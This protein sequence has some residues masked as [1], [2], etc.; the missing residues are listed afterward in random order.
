MPLAA[1]RAA[2]QQLLSM[3]RKDSQVAAALDVSNAR[4]KAW[5]QRLIDEGVLEKQKKPAGYV[6]R[7]KQ[8]FE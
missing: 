6:V 5:L 4:A 2:I 7:Q 3:P 8:M 1:I